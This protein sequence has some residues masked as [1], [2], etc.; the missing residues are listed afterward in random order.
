MAKRVKIALLERLDNALSDMYHNASPA[1]CQEIDDPDGRFFE[2]MCEQGSWTIEYIQEGLGHTA[3]GW[4]KAEKL[5]FLHNE[6]FYWLVQRITEYGELFQWGRGGRT[7]APK[8]LVLHR[9]GG[10]FKI[11]NAQE[12]EF[13]NMSNADLTDMIQVLEAFNTYVE[14]WNSRESMLSMYKDFQEQEAE[15]EAERLANLCPSCGK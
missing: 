5:G 7:V 9:G 13:E 2:F 11:L 15:Y 3:K 12:P 6:R 4:K 8:N 14:N 10:S 1:W